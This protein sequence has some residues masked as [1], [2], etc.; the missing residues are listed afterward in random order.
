MSDKNEPSPEVPE[1]PVTSEA[2]A[3]ETPPKR[4]FRDRLAGTGD[5]AYGTRGL[6]AA[7]L[8]ALIVGGFGGAAIHAAVDGDR[9]EHGRLFRGEGPGD[10]GPG[11]GGRMG[12]GFDGERPGPPG[13]FRQAPGDVPEEV[14]PTSTPDDEESSRRRRLRRAIRQATR[15][16]LPRGGGR[17][18]RVGAERSDVPPPSRPPFGG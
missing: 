3:A 17:S 8:A 7:T 5:R 9:H 1:S 10:M 18:P 12:G 11:F 16:W 2:P 4:T 14:P 6:I 13:D 15:S